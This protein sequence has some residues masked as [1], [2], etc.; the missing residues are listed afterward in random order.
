[1]EQLSF[2]REHI[3]GGSYRAYVHC[4]LYASFVDVRDKTSRGREYGK[5]RPQMTI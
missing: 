2:V 1:V 4:V 5:K 3:E